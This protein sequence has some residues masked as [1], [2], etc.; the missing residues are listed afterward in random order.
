MSRY[1]PADLAT[2]ARMVEHARFAEPSRYRA[3]VEALHRRTGRPR[4]W[5]ATQISWMAQN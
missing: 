4:H 3:L 2:M 1:H 5:I